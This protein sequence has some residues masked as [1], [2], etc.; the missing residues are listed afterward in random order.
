MKITFFNTFLFALALSAA[1]SCTRKE[2]SPSTS[3][4]AGDYSIDLSAFCQGLETKAR[5]DWSGEDVYNENKL[6]YID[7]F[8]FKSASD[9]DEALLSGRLTPPSPVTGT[10]SLGTICLD[11]IIDQSSSFYVCAIANLP[12]YSDHASMPKTLAGLRAVPV[13]G[14]FNN[15]DFE[16]Q[17][18]FVMRGGV[19][20]ISFTSSDKKTPK[21]VSIPL[22]RL[23]AKVSAVLN[24]VPAIDERET[25]ADGSKRYVRTWYPDVDHMEVYLS[26]ANSNISVAPTPVSYN[27]NF[28]TYYRTYFKP[29]VPSTAPSWDGEKWDITGSPFYTYPMTWDSDSPQAPFLKV[30]IKW[31]AYDESQN[32]TVA[33]VTEAT[34]DGPKFVRHQRNK[35]AAYMLDDNGDPQGS[36]GTEVYKEF[37]YKI[38]L[39]N[40]DDT[41]GT[42]EANDWLE[43]TADLSILGSTSDDLPVIL[44]GTSY[45]TDWG[46]GNSTSDVLRQAKYL[47]VERD[48]YEVYAQDD[49]TIPVISSH[50]LTSYK[51]KSATYNNYSSGSTVSSNLSTWNSSTKQLASPDYISFDEN[52]SF[53]LHHHLITDYTDPNLEC[54]RITY[55]VT[56]TN[57]GGIES[58]D[59]TIIQYPPL[60]IEAQT[61]NAV[62]FVNGNTNNFSTSSGSLYANYFSGNVIPIYDDGSNALF[63][64]PTL[65]ANTNSYTSSDSKISITFDT[66]STAAAKVM[67]ANAAGEN[68][69]ANIHITS[70]A[71]YWI[72][73]VELTYSNSPA[74]YTTGDVAQKSDSKVM[75]NVQNSPKS[76]FYGEASDLTISYKRYTTR[77]YTVSGITVYYHDKNFLG[78]VA[79]KTGHTGAQSNKNMYTI[80]VTDVSQLE[81]FI[82]NT[83][84]ATSID[85]DNFTYGN[86]KQGGTGSVGTALT[87][88]FPL[89]I[90]T[91]NDNA[92]AP[93]FLVASTQGGSY[94]G[95]MRFESARERCASYQENGYPAGRWRLPTDAEIKFII[96]LSARNK[97]PRLFNGVF[98]GSSG[99]RGYAIDAS[100][101]SVVSV[102]DTTDPA[103]NQPVASIRCVYPLWYWGDEHSTYATSWSGWQNN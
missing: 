30:I 67:N 78:T 83:R 35:P 48:L 46:T 54:A 86:L 90:T 64:A 75:S 6:V 62:V 68:D 25:L 71:P 52:N 33:P 5:T 57:E 45:V 3:M 98:W 13:T 9:G 95:G 31:T 89:D 50:N 55:V 7:W 10:A 94:D 34:A 102:I 24:V 58:K 73:R 59:I 22:T 47:S 76:R 11:D 27:N 49:I 79:H 44:S 87:G 65:A 80:S 17:G 82:S 100:D 101:P 18:S 60:Y 69:K 23:A 97:I 103:N 15:P 19:D 66:N 21:P 88:Y 74:S 4:G 26:F 41:Y 92:I 40:L 12:G 93:K 84:S 63:F 91:Y 38:P 61:S 1:V 28:F 16:P 39:I 85:F 72:Y 99:I 29:T 14:T 42:L 20:G 81:F 8:V 56:V 70:V 2:E 77:P 32:G 43:V 51:V 96:Y 53:T 36:G 37:Y